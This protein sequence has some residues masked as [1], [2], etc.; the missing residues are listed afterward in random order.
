MTILSRALRKVTIDDGRSPTD[1]RWS[2]Y[3]TPAEVLALLD[4]GAK[5]RGFAPAD[6]E[7]QARQDLASGISGQRHYRMTLPEA[8]AKQA[9]AVMA[10]MGKPIP[11]PGVRPMT[12][13]GPGDVGASRPRK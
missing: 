13:K 5:L 4:A 9:R 10:E 7:A 6:Y 1:G 3:C 12:R 2:A 8:L 11:E